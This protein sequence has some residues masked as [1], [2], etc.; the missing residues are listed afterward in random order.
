MKAPKMKPIGICSRLNVEY[1]LRSTT[2]CPATKKKLS[3]TVQV[4]NDS[5][6]I[7]EAV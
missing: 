5:P 4:P 3:I 2:I 7:A 1:R 6:V